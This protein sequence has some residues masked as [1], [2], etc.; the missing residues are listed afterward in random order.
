MSSV[1]V[2]GDGLAGTLLAARLRAQGVQVRLYGDGQSNTPPVALVHLFAGRS[3]ARSGLELEAFRSA[4]EQWRAEPLASEHRVRRRLDPGGR[5]QRSLG[6]A[7]LPEEYAPRSGDRGADS[8]SD[9]G[10]AGG[11]GPGGAGGADS[12]S[13]GGAGPG[14]GA[15]GAGAGA[16]W[17]EYGPAFSVAAGRL[18]QRELASLGP[19]YRRGP[20]DPGS[21][22][23][24]K[25]LALGARAAEA[26]PFLDWDLSVGRTVEARQG[27]AEPPLAEIVVGNG[28]H[29]APHPGRPGILSLGGRFS[30]LQGW[31]GDELERARALAGLDCREISAWQGQRCTPRRDH[32]P[33]LGWLDSTTFLFC[34][35]GSRGLFWLPYCLGLACRA[36]LDPASA[37]PPPLQVARCLT[38]AAPPG[39]WR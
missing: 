18:H 12:D 22:P 35:F 16:A 30:A 14:G 6:R 10:G 39:I 20:V 25:V 2:V 3:F 11:H 21:L 23:G 32:W 7:A 15:G 13:G 31:A 9:S 36:L 33:L 38:A 4:V 28:V 8:D 29:I 37:V 26:L 19:L 1:Q 34:G 17:M 24:V 5:L 27:D